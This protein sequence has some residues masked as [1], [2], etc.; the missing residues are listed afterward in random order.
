MVFKREL[1]ILEVK[2]MEDGYGKCHQCRKF[3]TSEC[4]TSSKYQ[5]FD[6]RPYFEPKEK[7]KFTISKGDKL[8]F[9]LLLLYILAVLVS[10]LNDKE[11]IKILF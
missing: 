6:D 3:G 11:L 7:K 1:I 5:K 9:L 10:I 2:S 4:P 8:S